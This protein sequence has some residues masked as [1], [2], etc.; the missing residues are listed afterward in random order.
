MFEDAILPAEMEKLD[1]V[2]SDV[3]ASNIQTTSQVRKRIALIHG[4]NMGHTITGINDNTSLEAFRLIYHI[5][6]D[7]YKT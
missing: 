3:T 7:P 4:H 6:I 5:T 1:E 2:T